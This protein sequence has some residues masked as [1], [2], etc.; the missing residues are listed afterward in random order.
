MEDFGIIIACCDQDYLFA[1]GCCASIRYFLG[2][3]PIC[4]L[5]DGTFSVSPLEKA[6]GVRVINHDSVSEPLLRN[7]SFG[8]GKSHMIP[9]WESPWQN[10]LVMDADTI[11]WGDVLKFANFQDFDFIIDQPCNDY[12]DADITEFFFDIP[13]VEKYFPDFHWRDYRSRYVCPGTFFG[14][15]GVFSLEEYRKILDFNDEHPEIFKYGDM[16]FFNLMV[17]RAAQEGKLR[18]QNVDMQL[19][20]PDFDQDLLRKRFPVESSGPA[21]DR[22]QATVIHWCGPKPTLSSGKVYSE[23][24]NFC[25]RKCEEDV[26]NRTGLAAEMSLQVEDLQRSIYVYKN[27]F[28]KK[29]RQLAGK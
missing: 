5:I 27:K 21:G 18:V 4:L 29:F 3:V 24:M 13:G 10:F 9:F 11:V 14:K 20:V 28:K 26:W 23:P 6:Y 2:D 17:F 12:S 16:G 8:W 22:T 19:L 7:R 25:R 15:R 1:K